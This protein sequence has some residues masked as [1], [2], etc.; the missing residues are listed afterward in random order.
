MT[1]NIA[2]GQVVREDGTAPVYVMCAGTLVHIPTPDALF[3]LGY[4]WSDVQVVADGALANLPKFELPSLAPTPPSMVF[5]M[6]KHKV[7]GEPSSLTKW[8]ARTELPGITLPNGNRIV[9][10]RGVFTNWSNVVNPVDPD[11]SW[12]LIPAASNLDAS[13]VDP[14]RFFKVG[15]ILHSDS[16][17]FWNGT[18][19][20]PDRHAW[21]ATPVFHLEISGWPANNVVT[22]GSMPEDWGH[23]LAAFGPSWP[24]DVDILQ[25]LKEV[26]VSGS[27]VTDEPHIPPSLTG[28]YGNAAADWAGSED[29]NPW[30]EDNAARWTEVHSPDSIVPDPSHQGTDSLIGVV[31]VARTSVF[32]PSPKTQQLNVNIACPVPPP[33][34]T[35]VLTV[36]EYVLAETYPPS[37]VGGNANHTGASFQVLANNTFDLYVEVQGAAFQGSAGRFAAVYRMSWVEKTKE[38]EKEKE[39]EKDHKEKE[40]DK[41]GLISTRAEKVTDHAAAGPDVVEL[42]DAQLDDKTAGN[43]TPGGGTAQ[44]FIRPER[45][46]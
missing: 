29:E 37:I 25:S 8:W 16:S 1:A 15:D 33:T 5:A 46:P 35:S 32:D 30:A 12:T 7:S 6:N 31:V 44:V 27:L 17:P 18:P 21:V 14:S 20:D 10:V 39:K 43:P 28:G 13:G 24:Y 19:A 23:Q 34:P 40:K 36:R 22:T 42:T 9:A 26:V 41:E 11:I 4:S 45:R 38:K 3:S 2:N